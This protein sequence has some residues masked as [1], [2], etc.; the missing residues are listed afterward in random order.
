MCDFERY[1]PGLYRTK[2]IFHDFPS[3]GIFKKKFQDFPG[4]MGTLVKVQ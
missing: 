3:S 1:F 2:V 4:G